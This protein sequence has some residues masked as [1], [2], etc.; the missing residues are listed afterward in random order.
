M[1]TKKKS[2]NLSSNSDV[3]KNRLGRFLLAWLPPVVWAG[4]IFAFSAQSIL[5]GF[6]TN[7]L[8]FI[9]KKIAHITVYAVLYFLVFRAV[10]LE[11]PNKSP[12]SKR[13]YLVPFLV[14]LLYASIDELHQSFVPGRHATI[15]DIGYDLLGGS[16]VFFRIHGYI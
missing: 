8:D 12:R 7:T 13:Y 5:P 2:P 6:E 14:V 3:R 10:T 11:H 15:R 9:F 1:S 16:G 4:I